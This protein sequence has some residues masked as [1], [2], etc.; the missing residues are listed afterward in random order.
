MSQKKSPVTKKSSLSQAKINALFISE[1]GRMLNELD[2]L[3]ENK[4]IIKGSKELRSFLINIH[5]LR[6]ALFVMDRPDLS[7][8]AER[9]ENLTREEET[10]MI[11]AET[12]A[13]LKELRELI[14]QVAVLDAENKD[15]KV[16]ISECDEDR[17]FLCDKLQII[18][19]ACDDYN[20]CVIESTLKQLRAKKWSKDTDDL[21]VFISDQLLLG[22]FGKISAAIRGFL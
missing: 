18:L 9:I 12:P 16:Y 3:I 15:N 5:G 21:L 1:G 20:D 6:S 17:L 22:N 7:A 10:E 11:Y 19:Y 13:F 2:N 14:A 8:I 4:S